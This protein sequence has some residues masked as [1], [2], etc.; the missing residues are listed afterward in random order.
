MF[1]SFA[2]EHNDRLPAILVAN[3]QIQAAIVGRQVHQAIARRQLD[4]HVANLGCQLRALFGQF[5]GR[6]GDADYQQNQ[7]DN[8]QC[9]HHADEKLEPG[10]ILGPVLGHE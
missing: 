10:A 2:I 7:A 4:R 1:A 3:G 8:Q 6:S 9:G 5:L